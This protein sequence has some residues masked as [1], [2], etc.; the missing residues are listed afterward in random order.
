MDDNWLAIKPRKKKSAPKTIASI[1]PTLTPRPASI[2][3][4]PH[5][6]PTEIQM[7]D[8]GR[9]ILKGLTSMTRLR[10]SITV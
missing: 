6:R 1:E 5:S 7:S 3:G 9:N 8:S 2:M 4:I 10:I